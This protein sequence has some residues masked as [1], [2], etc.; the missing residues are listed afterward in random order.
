MGR[1]REQRFSEYLYLM[2][3]VTQSSRR[4]IKLLCLI[5]RAENSRPRVATAIRAR[6]ALERAAGPEACSARGWGL[7]CPPLT[8]ARCLSGRALPSAGTALLPP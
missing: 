2:G 7:L 6:R 5:G 4:G 3:G 8:S 1:G